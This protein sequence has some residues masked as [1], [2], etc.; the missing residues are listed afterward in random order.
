MSG[1][2][3]MITFIIGFLIAG[4]VNS[5]DYL[6]IKSDFSEVKLRL[7]NEINYDSVY[8][9]I[10]DYA[11]IANSIAK[12]KTRFSTAGLLNP[13]LAAN[14][15][16]SKETTIAYGMYTAN[17]AYVRH[18]E[19]VQ[20]CMDYLETVRSLADRLAINPAEFNKLVPV[21]ESSLYDNE[22][23]FQITDSLLSYGQKWFT[24]AEL[25]GLSSLFLGG[26]WIESLFLGIYNRDINDIMIKETIKE[27]FKLLNTINYLFTVIE[28]DG[29][30]SDFKEQLLSLE[31]KKYNNPNL[32]KDIEDVRNS[33]IDFAPT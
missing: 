32:I 5:E 6:R 18:F 20:L 16:N 13:D 21:I 33:I 22:E 8:R 14:F 23:I 4:C 12:T 10:P 27:H 19:R 1:K 24:Q 26:F 11:Y 17:L 7:D 29:I 2:F 30:I 9:L 15:I 3:L 25:H 28:D 31:Q